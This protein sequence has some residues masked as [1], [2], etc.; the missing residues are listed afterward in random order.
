MI[1]QFTF[2]QTPVLKRSR[3]RFDLSH[4]NL[5]SGNMGDLIPFY[6]QEVYPGDT[7]KMT[8][9][10]VVRMSNPLLKPIMDN[11]F[12]DTYFF[13]VPSRLVYDDWQR[14]F[15]ENTESPWANTK[16]YEV[17]KLGTSTPS[18]RVVSSKTV[19]DYLGLPVGTVPNDV[20]VTLIPFRGFAK[21]WDDWFR[22]QNNVSPMHIQKGAAGTSEYLNVAAWAPN[23]YMGK[24]P[25]VA[26]MHDYFTSCLPSP[27]KGTASEIPL[28]VGMLPVKA[29]EG[30]SVGAT[31]KD[32]LL[33]K[34]ANISGTGFD[35]FGASSTGTF[36]F[37]NSSNSLSERETI[38]LNSAG[39]ITGGSSYGDIVPD[40]LF[41]DGTN[42]GAGVTVNDLRLAFQMQKMLERDARGGTRYVEYL[43]SH[44]GV[45][46][47]DARLQRSEFLGGKRTPLNI[48]QVTQTSGSTSND[49]GTEN[50]GEQG[51][52]SLS[53]ARSRSTKGFVEH[54]FVFGVCCIRQ[55]HTYQQG[56][57][58][59]WTRTKRTDFYDPVFANIGEQPVY[60]SEIFAGAGKVPFGYN[61]AWADLRYRPNKVTGEMRS[62]A[63]NTLDLWHLA[64][65]Y[66]NAPTL[67][68]GFIEETPVYLDRALTVSSDTQDQF[69]LD[70][71]VQNIA[72]RELPTYSIP[73]LIDHN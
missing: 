50:L 31:P 60:K 16:E 14:V 30:Q 64:D 59:F 36:G 27:Q 51:A 67:N 8:A 4:K 41:A 24:L 35:S 44:F 70:F 18:M 48:N 40:N 20:D 61:E 26:K 25:K 23:N 12:L 62:A 9:N 28:S 72:Y 7:F 63:S 57:E 53:F 29:V 73:S 2:S 43:L 33:V 15:G 19:A 45:S 68:Q 52:Y 55:F 11:L 34:L 13:F 49:V 5:T 71:Y 1:K 46:S 3:S 21:V 69:I 22:D 10:C 38:S 54:G 42:V 47:G 58:K 65:N 17:P 37:L 32:K 56:V 66:T 6:L 39:S